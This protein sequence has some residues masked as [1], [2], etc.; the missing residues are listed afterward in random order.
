MRLVDHLERGDANGAAGAMHQLDRLR[1]H[2]VYPVANDR[3]SLAAAY[4]HQYPRTGDGLRD[5]SGQASGDAAVAIFVEILHDGL[6]VTR[7]S[8]VSS[9]VCP[10]SSSIRYDRSA[11]SR[12]IF[13]IANPTWTTT[14]SPTPASGTYWRHTCR[15]IPANLTLPRRN[16]FSSRAA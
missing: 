4:F 15:V 13:E 7:L 14:K 11:S 5:F 2:P 3:V 1:D 16:P 9:E 12:S 10:R 6:L 8:S